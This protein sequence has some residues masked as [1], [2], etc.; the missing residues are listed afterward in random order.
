MR[1]SNY[2][3]PWVNLLKITKDMT[4]VKIIQ[5]IGQCKKLKKIFIYDKLCFSII[6][7]FY[8]LG[9]FACFLYKRYR[10]R[11]FKNRE[12]FPSKLFC[13][14]LP[15]IA[16]GGYSCL[17]GTCSLP[18]ALKRQHVVTST[19]PGKHFQTPGSHTGELLTDLV[20]Y[21]QDSGD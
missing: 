18:P 9:K 4:P 5:C 13:F 6:G 11:T 17:W 7:I 14:S 8:L 20:Q 2:F 15:Q 21:T 19:I 12:M 3:N 16:P 10:L 1:H